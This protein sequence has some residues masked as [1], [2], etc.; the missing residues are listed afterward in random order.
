MIH[1]KTI[2][3]PTDFSNSSRYALEAAVQ[4]ARAQ[5]SR[6]LLLHVLPRPAMAVSTEIP[7]VK[8][9]HGEEDLIAYRHEVDRLLAKERETAAFA[10]IEQVL[11]EG[12]VADVIMRV[13]ETTPCDLIVMGSQGK[14]R[15]HEIMMGSVA[16]TVMRKAAC[17]VM[18]VKLP[19]TVGKAPN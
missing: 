19:A 17:P 15:M 1:L 16:A 14:S 8:A 13:A 11:Q 3:V 5:G 18:T 9:E 10:Q 2:L 6:L 7:A 12:P 4:L